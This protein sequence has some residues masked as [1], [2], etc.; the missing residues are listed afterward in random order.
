[1]N[2][3]TESEIQIVKQALPALQARV[4]LHEPRDRYRESH[5]YAID[6]V[7]NKIAAMA[8]E[9]NGTEGGF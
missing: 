3:L 9:A 6:Q 4:L 1:M 2:Q 7:I 8:K 5:L